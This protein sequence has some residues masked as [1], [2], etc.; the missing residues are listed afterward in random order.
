MNDREE[1]LAR[2]ITRRLDLG[3]NAIDPLTL[4]ELR[5]AREAALMRHRPLPAWS[6][7]TAGGPHPSRSAVLRNFNPRYI[8]SIAALLFVVIGMIYLQ[9][10]QHNDDVT[11]I[12]AKLLSGDLPIDAYLDKGLDSWLKRPSQ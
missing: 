3:L 4:A 1:Y 9:H 6:L 2:R 12:D 7:V 10:L 8:L 5:S 11:D